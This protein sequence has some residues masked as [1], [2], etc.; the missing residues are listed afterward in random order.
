MSPNRKELD[1][2]LRAAIAANERYDRD[3]SDE[4]LAR[5]WDADDRY[6]RAWNRVASDARYTE[7]P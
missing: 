1:A 6:Q 4:N 2:A 7:G 3:P 5:V